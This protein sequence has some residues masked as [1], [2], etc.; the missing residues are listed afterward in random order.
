MGYPHEAGPRSFFFAASLCSNALPIYC[1][2]L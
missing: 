2:Q 1:L